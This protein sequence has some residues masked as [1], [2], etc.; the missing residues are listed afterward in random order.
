MHRSCYTTNGSRV[1]LKK[2]DAATARSGE[3]YLSNHG[4]V[5]PN[6]EKTVQIY[7]GPI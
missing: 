1:T 5:V 4:H 2:T 6:V 7:T 3:G